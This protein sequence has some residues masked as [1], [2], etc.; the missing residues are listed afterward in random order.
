[1]R[2]RP[3]SAGLLEAFADFY[4]TQVL[5]TLPR[6]LAYH[7]RV[8]AN[9]LDI[10]RRELHLGGRADESELKSLQTL[11][12]RDGDLESLN[13]LLCER[14]GRGDIDLEAPA[15]A[16]HLWRVTLDKLAIDQPSYGAYRREAGQDTDGPTTRRN[17]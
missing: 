15:L 1:M 3:S 7:G 5:P 14:I 10:V 4:R 6:H 12:Q 2:D 17:R 13:K 11:L 16:E 8:A 9:V